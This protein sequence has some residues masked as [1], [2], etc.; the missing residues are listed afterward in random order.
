[1]REERERERKKKK[2]ILKMNERLFYMFGGERW[3]VTWTRRS[4]RR[5]PMSNL[6]GGKR[7]SVKV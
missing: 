5:K 1:M 7:K 4:R 6:K 3:G 2:Q